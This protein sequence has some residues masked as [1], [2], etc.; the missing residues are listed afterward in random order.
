ME[1]LAAAKAV[2][3]GKRETKRL[4]KLNLFEDDARQQGYQIVAGVDEAGRGPL[5]GPVVAAACMIPAGVLIPGVNDSKLLTPQERSE[6]YQRIVQDE[7]ISY[8][9]GIIDH[10][11]IDR[12]N[13]FQATIAAM[14]MAVIKLPIEPEML[15]VDGLK[16]PHPTIPTQKII[17]GDSKSQ[18]IA[19]AS[20]IAKE[21][22]DQLMRE[23][24]LQWPQYKFDQ[25]KG[26]AVPEHLAALQTHGVSPIHRL[27]FAPV[28]ALLNEEDPQLQLCFDGVSD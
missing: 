6:I 28:K 22:R 14:L 26:Y 10:K 27:S 13:I 7:R 21:T 1:T 19:A 11:T 25:H 12:I 16:L 4:L 24:H 17:K 18:S 3:I 20:I 5:A 2:K 8:G 15:L 9:I 23:Y